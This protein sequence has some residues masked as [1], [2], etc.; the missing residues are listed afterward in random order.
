MH[1]FQI[2]YHDNL[3]QK[4]CLDCANVLQ[5]I[6]EFYNL[7]ENSQKLLKLH[8]TNVNNLTWKENEILGIQKIEY[9]EANDTDARADARNTEEY[10]IEENED[11]EENLEYQFLNEESLDESSEN[12]KEKAIKLELECRLC[13][14]IYK[15]QVCSY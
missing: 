10:K 2:K 14:K 11:N 9:L 6:S 1:I 13:G 7:C 3:P 4:I 8:Y 12:C 15:H 5:T